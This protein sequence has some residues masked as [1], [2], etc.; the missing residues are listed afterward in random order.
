MKKHQSTIN[1]NE[2]LVWFMVM[3]SKHKENSHWTLR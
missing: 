3:L 2:N 1:W